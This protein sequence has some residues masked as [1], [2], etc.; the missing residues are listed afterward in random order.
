MSSLHG[1]W[2]VAVLL[3]AGVASMAIAI[4][5]SLEIALPAVALVLVITSF[6]VLRWLPPDAPDPD[7]GAIG[8]E[9]VAAVSRLRV[10]ALCAIAAGSFLSEGV[11]IEWSALLLRDGLGARA[12]IAGL[13]VVAFSAGMAVSRFL[14]DRAADRLG[15]RTL[16]RIGA[17]TGALALGASLLVGDATGAIIAFAILGL[18]LGAVVPSAFRAAGGL[19]LAPDRTALAIVV[20]AGYVGSI[21]GPLVV[22]LTADRFGLRVAFVIPVVASLLASAAA[23]ATEEVRAGSVG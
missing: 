21:V 2:S 5:A 23:G 19:R 14:G 9:P 17:A 20:T 4:G 7:G 22:G 10:L 13:G 16:V 18:G 3:G 11:A 8:R 6:P 15:E 12:A 1:T